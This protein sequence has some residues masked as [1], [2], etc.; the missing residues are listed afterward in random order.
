MH[1]DSIYLI[2]ALGAIFAG[3]VQGLSGF[4][5][6]MVAMSFWAWT[7]DPKLSVAMVVFGALTGQ[8]LAAITVRRK[9]NLP[10]LLPFI[11]GG[12]IGI[13]I[14]VFLLPHIDII[15]FRVIFGLLLVTWCPMMLMTSRLPSIKSGGCIA[16]SIVGTIGGIMG[17][18]GGFAGTV[19]TLWCTL[20]GYDKD[21][22]R[23]IIQNFNLAVLMVTMATYISTGIV[24][25][26][27]IPMFAIVFPAMLIPTLIGTRLYFRISDSV[28]KKTVLILLSISGVTLLVSSLPQL[29]WK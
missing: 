9:S 14:G 20:R 21:T 6:G 16:D 11:I 12:I 3:F 8:V 1:I 15:T 13:P 4:A 26:E 2:V 25:R 29:I 18:L 5:F 24:T 10:M 19:P 27:M 22:Q 23:S 28:F 17:G 7:I